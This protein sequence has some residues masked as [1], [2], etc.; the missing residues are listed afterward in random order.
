MAKIDQSA[1]TGLIRGITFAYQSTNPT[2]LA[3]VKRF[4]L[5]PEKQ[6]NLIQEL[7]KLGS[8]TY[9]E[10]IWPL[11]YETYDSLLIGVDQTINMGLDVWLEINLLRLPTS[12]DLHKE[13]QTQYEF[14]PSNDPAYLRPVSNTW[15]DHNT[16]VNGMVFYTWATSLFYFGFGRP[17]LQHLKQTQSVSQSVDAFIKF[18]EQHL[19]LNNMTGLIR[20]FWSARING[21]PEPMLGIFKQDTRLW[22]PFIHLASWLQKDFD[23]FK[24]HV[25][26][27]A[28]SQGLD[29]DVA[30]QLTDKCNSSTMLFE[31]SQFD[32]LF[33]FVEHYYAYNRKKGIACLTR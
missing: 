10:M 17:V 7:K 26:E 32:N 33:D 24:Q 14:G 25:F 11:P 28:V 2:T 5:V 4:N 16:V 20:D 30:K 19:W 18:T 12:T 29:Q 3:A 23:K 6:L 31:Q 8:P 1:G 15:L 27:F 21:T 13:Y 22:L 9:A